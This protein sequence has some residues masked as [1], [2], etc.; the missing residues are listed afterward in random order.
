[1]FADE[2]RAVVDGAVA[3]E[4]RAVRFGEG[5]RMPGAGEGAASGAQAAEEDEDQGL[6]GA[7]QEGGAVRACGGHAFPRNAIGGGT[8]VVG[9][10]GQGCGG[11]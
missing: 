2:M 7:E 9:L 8:V 6:D 10:R 11:K 5:G 1:M 3:R 4:G